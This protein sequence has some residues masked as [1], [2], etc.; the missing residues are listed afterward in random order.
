VQADD[1]RTFVAEREEEMTSPAEVVPLTGMRG[2]IAE[3]MTS[4]YR[5]A[6]HIALGMDIDMEAF[7]EA[8]KRL[9]I[10]AQAEDGPSVSITALLVRAVA[11]ALARHP[12]LNSTLRDEE[13]H[14]L[15]DVNIGVA[16][17]LEEGLIVPVVKEADR[18][19]VGQIAA[20]LH[21]LVE[22]ARQ[23]RLRSSDLTG[24]TFTISNLGPFGVDEFTAIINPPEAA[25]LAV[26]AIR[27]RLVPDGAGGIA[28]RPTMRLTL[29]ADH[30]IVDGAT[31]ARFLSD[32]RE[33]LEDPALLLW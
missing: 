24:G 28:A 15:P 4:S 23:N 13:I 27:K 26:G 7:E 32:L 22:R 29:S 10:R 1:V 9:S 11:W 17:A 6:P 5:A 2:A 14:L 3:R 16:V 18:K 25:I 8:R 31:A 19:A 20:E 12:W 30:R 33:A 21:E